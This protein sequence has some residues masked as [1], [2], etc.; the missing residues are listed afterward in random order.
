SLNHL[1]S[2]GDL[3]LDLGAISGAHRGDQGCN[4]WVYRPGRRLGDDVSSKLCA[5]ID[6]GAQEPD[7]VVRERPGRRHLQAAVAVNRAADQLAG[8]AVPD[9]YDGAIIATAQGIL[10]QVKPQAGLLNLTPMAGVTFLCKQRLDVL[11]IVNFP[12][13]CRR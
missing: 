7:F 9:L 5:L 2:G 10:T 8:G 1:W 11:P 13:G 6:P 12:R 4:F 3:P